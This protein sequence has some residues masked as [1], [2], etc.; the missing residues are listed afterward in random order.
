MLNLT[1]LARPVFRRRVAASLLWADPDGMERTQRAVLA[2]LLRRGAATDY[3]RRYG[4]DRIGAYEDFAQ[5]VPVVQYE[6][7]RPDVMRMVSGAR[8]VLW[9]GVCR[10]YA[11]SSG[12]SG[13]KSK[14]I[15][16]TDTSLRV[17]HYGG[18]AASVAHYLALYPQSRLFGGKS[19]I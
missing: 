4:M 18:A 9:P 3:G 11:Q 12:T 2:W 13:G 8:D 16:I 1:S 7:I 10:R 6:D 14:Y 5:A 17:N 19:F 15:P